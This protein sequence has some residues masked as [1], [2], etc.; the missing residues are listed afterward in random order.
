M[1]AR[2][3]LESH[4][5]LSKDKDNPSIPNII[6]GLKFLNENNYMDVRKPSDEEIANQKDFI[7]LDESISISVLV[8]R[9]CSDKKP[10]AKINCKNNR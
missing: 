9:F 1:M 10:D 2:S 8:R 7:V 4:L 6:Q 5:V 3:F